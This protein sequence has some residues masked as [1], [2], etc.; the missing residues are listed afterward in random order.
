MYNSYYLKLVS[1]CVLV[2]TFGIRN[3]TKNINQQQFVWLISDSKITT[4]YLICHP[5][6]VMTAKH[7]RVMDSKLCK[8]TDGSAFHVFTRSD[9]SCCTF[10][11]WGR[12]RKCRRNSSQT[13]SNKYR[14]DLHYSHF[15]V[16]VGLLWNAG[17][18]TSFFDKV[19]C[20]SLYHDFMAKK[21]FFA[22]LFL[23]L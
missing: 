14:S 4:Q 17:V 9:S 12:V 1:F 8:N 18:L 6:T 7:R 15:I 19:S 20:L 23:K 22:L 13:V 2:N 21:H 16:L 5:Q 10:C 3:P 11:C